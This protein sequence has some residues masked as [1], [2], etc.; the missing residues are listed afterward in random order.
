MKG[1]MCTRCRKSYPLSGYNRHKK[2]Y[3]GRECICRECAADKYKEWK[4]K[5]YGVYLES[6]RTWYRNN[7]ERGRAN[8]KRWSENNPERYAEISL[9][10]AH[11]RRT[12][13]AGNGGSY[14]TKEWHNLC[15]RTGWIC[16]RCG[17][18]HDESKLTADHVTP[19]SKG[20]T[21]NIDNIQP[22]CGSC[23]SSKGNRHMT[24]YRN[25]LA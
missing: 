18:S 3:D 13:I 24:D 17:K 8:S 7:T 19:I 2:H 4:E 21:S 1:K 16:L 5:N 9:R 15:E 11:K 23:N 10:A 20:G 14:T 12:R 6:A 25:E 22:L